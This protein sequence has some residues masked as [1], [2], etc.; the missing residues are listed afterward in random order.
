M[1]YYKKKGIIR[2]A[3]VW[4][5]A[6]L[7]ALRPIDVVRHKFVPGVPAGSYSVERL[8]T[9][10]TDLAQSEDDLWDLIAKNTRYEIKRAKE[11]D[12][13]V[14]ITD[15]A[16][17]E[18]KDEK[19]KE[20]IGFFNGFA[21]TKN[22]SSIGY[23][24]L[25]QFYES[26]NLVVRSVHKSESEETIAMHAY[27]LSDGRARLYQSSSHFRANNDPEFRKMT[28]RAN[29]LLHWEDMLYFKAQGVPTYDM[30]G[31]YGGSEDS[32]KL[33]INQFKE[34][35]GGTRIDETSCIVAVT[36]LGWMSIAMR[37]IIRGK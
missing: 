31:W 11:R 9:L 26:G 35:F 17:G 3:E 27:I 1:I 10:V 29:R 13:V 22:R 36:P 34:S 6:D 32:E 5:E 28:G 20:Y 2:V 33:A 12:G 7:P 15:L 23:G 37:N 21:E 16:Q 14:T 30:G 4:F 25:A 18:R 24:D 19:L 8:S